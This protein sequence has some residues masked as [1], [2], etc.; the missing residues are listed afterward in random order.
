MSPGGWLGAL[1]VTALVALAL[2]GDDVSGYRF[3]AQDTAHALEGP[4]ARR[5]SRC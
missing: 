5:P 2:V 3:D 4:S 1:L